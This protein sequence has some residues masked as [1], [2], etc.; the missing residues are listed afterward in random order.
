ME[1]EQ[2]GQDKVQHPSTE[3]LQK[4]EKEK[5]N[6]TPVTSHSLPETKLQTLREEID[7]A[8]FRFK[9]RLSFE[10]KEDD[11]SEK[12]ISPVIEVSEKSSEED[13]QKKLSS[14]HQV[15]KFESDVKENGYK[16]II[17][18]FIIPSECKCSQE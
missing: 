9:G 10:E 17:F 15:D 14:T 2:D 7:N 11:A 8:E 4:E 18:L 16:N 1:I 13:V 12:M 5:S 6:I 3:Q